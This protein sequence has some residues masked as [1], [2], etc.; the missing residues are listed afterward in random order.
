MDLDA[1]ARDLDA[2]PA[3]YTVWLAKALSVYSA[4]SRRD[5]A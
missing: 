1:L 4:I 2:H 3:R 5:S